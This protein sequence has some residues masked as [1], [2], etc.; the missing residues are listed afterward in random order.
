MRAKHGLILIIGL[1]ACGGQ[2]SDT[3]AEPGEDVRAT[4]SPTDGARPCDGYVERGL[5][6]AAEEDEA[7]GRPRDRRLRELLEAGLREECRFWLESGAT[8][9]EL[10]GALRDCDAVSCAEGAAAWTSCVAEGS[11]AAAVDRVW[12]PSAPAEWT[13]VELRPIPADVPSCETYIAWTIGC[14]REAMGSAVFDTAV[15]EPVR[16]EMQEACDAYEQAGIG[17]MLGPALAACAD[18]GCGITGTDLVTCIATELVRAVTGD[19]DGV[20]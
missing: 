20:P 10:D 18:V 6:C 9:E 11:P 5:R 14:L 13:R 7:G 3:T 4:A 1:V 12:M 15:G 2:A 16:G 8:R 19:G 17:G